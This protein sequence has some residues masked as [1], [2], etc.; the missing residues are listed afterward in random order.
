MSVRASAPVTWRLFNP[1][2]LAWRCW[3]GD[4]IVFD[5]FS[6]M[7]HYLDTTAGAVFELL[8]EGPAT[9]QGLTAEL[10]AMDDAPAID[11]LGSAVQYVLDRF[12][13]IGL[14][15]VVT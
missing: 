11:I 7:T 9:M 12:D 13:D 3:D 5:P 15:E 1:G 6:G 10:A 2:E 4:Y 8:L 14:A